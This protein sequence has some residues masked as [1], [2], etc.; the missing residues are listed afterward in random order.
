MATDTYLTIAERYAGMDPRMV[1][2]TPAE[3]AALLELAPKT[4]ES[5]RGDGTGPRFLK[6]G[7]T[8]AYRLCDVLDYIEGSVYSTTREATTSRR[9]ARAA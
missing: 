2:L 6:I 1:R 4:L 3:A 9:A 7:R 5:K 8:V